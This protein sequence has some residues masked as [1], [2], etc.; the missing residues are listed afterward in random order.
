MKWAH[1]QP[2]KCLENGSFWD[3]KWVKNGSKTRFSK[4]YPGRF[5]VHNQV[6]CAHFNYVLTRFS[7][8]VWPHVRTKLYTSHVP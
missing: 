3:Q 4:S 8:S 2:M 5:G 1:F 7:P 6:N